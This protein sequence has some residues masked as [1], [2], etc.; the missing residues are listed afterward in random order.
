MNSINLTNILNTKHLRIIVYGAAILVFAYEILVPLYSRVAFLFLDKV[1][2]SDISVEKKSISLV[3]KYL[4]SQSQDPEMITIVKVQAMQWPDA[5]LGT[6]SLIDQ[7][8]TKLVAGYKVEI[9]A[10]KE[11]FFVH[12]DFPW[13]KVYLVKNGKRV[14]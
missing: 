4:A 5:S 10:D 3:L 12:A 9:L 8:N 6:A 7:Y 14:A 13:Q 2:A 1:Y 11:T